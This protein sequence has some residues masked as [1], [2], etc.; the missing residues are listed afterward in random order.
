MTTVTTPMPP[1]PD[2]TRPQNPYGA[3][4]NIPVPNKSS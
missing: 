2:Q 4:I 3:P 1:R